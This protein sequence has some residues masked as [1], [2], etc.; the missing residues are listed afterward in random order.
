MPYFIKSFDILKKVPW[1]QIFRQDFFHEYVI[2]TGL[3]ETPDLFGEIK[4][5]NIKNS[6]KPKKI[7]RA[8]MFPQIGSSE[9]S[10]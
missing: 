4:L 7:N 3:C 2:R 6:S 5:S 10:Q 1:L 9:K 8:Q